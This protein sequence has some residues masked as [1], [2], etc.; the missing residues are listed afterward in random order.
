MS[1]I[2]AARPTLLRALH[3]ARLFR[4]S[5][6]RDELVEEGETELTEKELDQVIT[7]LEE[8]AEAT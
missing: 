3:V 2:E 1:S 6:I 4:A 8:L 5:G 7:D